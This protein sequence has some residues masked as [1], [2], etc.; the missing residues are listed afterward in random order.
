MG[1]ASRKSEVGVKY[2]TSM[3][4]KLAPEMRDVNVFARVT[5]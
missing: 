2:H 4:Y 1:R 5:G 3:N